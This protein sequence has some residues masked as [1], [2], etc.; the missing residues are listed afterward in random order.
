[1]KKPSARPTAAVLI[2]VAALVVALGGTT[3]AASKINGSQIKKHSIAGNRLKNNTVTGKQI[4]ES[5][6]GTVRNANNAAHLGGKTAS[7][8]V[9]SKDVF[10]FSITMSKTDPTRTIGTFGPFTFKASCSVDTTSETTE[11]TLTAVANSAAWIDGNELPAGGFVPVLDEDSAD[12]AAGN[13]EFVGGTDDSATSA[14]DG[15][16]I[17]A[18]NTGGKDCRF[19]GTLF[20]AG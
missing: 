18:I 14:I 6:L 15:G 8:F 12:P 11:G 9:P 3:Y 5:T 7:S 20:N 16:V 10:R 17:T 2:G 4:K 1:M 13:F 19:F